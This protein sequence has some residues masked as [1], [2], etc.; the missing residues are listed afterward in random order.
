MPKSRGNKN[1]LRRATRKTYSQAERIA[2]LEREL[3]VLK[4]LAVSIVPGAAT[5]PIP[6][7]PAIKA[8]NEAQLELPGATHG[9]LG[10]DAVGPACGHRY[11]G[12]HNG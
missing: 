11:V 9:G 5:P 2:D 6:E 1:R 3:H 10:C 8:F 4:S 7:E 12:E